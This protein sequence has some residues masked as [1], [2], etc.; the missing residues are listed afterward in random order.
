MRARAVERER[1]EAEDRGERQG[2]ERARDR[3]AELLARVAR[4]GAELGDTAEHP[5]GDAVDGLTLP[6]GH[7]RVRELV[8]EDRPEEQEHCEH[9]GGEVGAVRVRGEGGELA[10]GQC[11]DE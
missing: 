2:G 1:Q 4:F 6:A 7:D 5:E 3:D 8:R 10:A 11:A 9:C